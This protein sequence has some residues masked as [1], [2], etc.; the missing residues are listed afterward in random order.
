MADWKI[1]KWFHREVRW[2]HSLEFIPTYSSPP[3]NKVEKVSKIPLT[4]FSIRILL[5]TQLPPRRYIKI[6]SRAFRTLRHDLLRE[7][8]L[9]GF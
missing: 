9:A 5:Q 6:R 3:I 2:R 1:W 7:F 4:F 8:R